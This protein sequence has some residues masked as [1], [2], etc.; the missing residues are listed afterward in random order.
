MFFII[1][2]IVYPLIF[3]TKISQNCSSC[4]STKHDN[5]AVNKNN[6]QVP[7]LNTLSN[8]LSLLAR[9]EMES[10]SSLEQKNNQE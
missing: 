7:R 3:S 5:K 10:K 2:S 6:I 9:H 8:L 1:H 4:S